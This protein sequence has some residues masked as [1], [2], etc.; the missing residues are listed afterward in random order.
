MDIFY[1]QYIWIFCIWACAVSKY[2][3]LQSFAYIIIIKSMS[4]PGA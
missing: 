1:L 4:H 2:S 3:R